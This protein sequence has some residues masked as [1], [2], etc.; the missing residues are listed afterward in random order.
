MR[1]T[2]PSPW[3]AIASSSTGGSTRRGV[4]P[5]LHRTEEALDTYSDEVEVPAMAAP[6]GANSDRESSTVVIR[7]KSLSR[8]HSSACAR[9]ATLL[10]DPLA[11]A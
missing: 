1:A 4:R 7:V 11:L 9:T 6:H 10:A 8:V 5:L 3:V 2:S